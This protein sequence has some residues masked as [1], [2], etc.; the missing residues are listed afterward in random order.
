MYKR[1]RPLPSPPLPVCFTICLG[2]IMCLISCAC[3][4]VNVWL[5][6]TCLCEC[7]CLCAMLSA[8]VC[9]LDLHV[10]CLQVYTGR[11]HTSREHNKTKQRRHT[12]QQDQ[13]EMKHK[14][15]GCTRY[16]F[17]FVCVAFIFAASHLSADKAYVTSSKEADAVAELTYVPLNSPAPLSWNGTAW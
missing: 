5:Y 16:T 8:R 9:V 7:L 15:V 14:A 2:M 10:A 13:N 17:A 11:R 12:P 3:V 1:Q 6:F 4:C